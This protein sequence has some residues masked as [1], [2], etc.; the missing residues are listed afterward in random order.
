MLATAALALA[1][2]ASRSVGLPAVIGN[3][4]CARDTTPW[5]P[6]EKGTMIRIDSCQK[7][8]DVSDALVKTRLERWLD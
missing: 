6:T 4:A 5:P 1:R 3:G 8:G 2:P 7:K